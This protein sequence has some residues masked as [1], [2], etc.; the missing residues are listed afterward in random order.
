M[1]SHSGLGILPGRV[2]RFPT[3][4]KNGEGRPLK[5][6]HMG[7]N[8]IIH[9]GRHPLLASVPSGAYGYFVHSYYC[10]PATEDFILARTDYGDWFTSIVGKD[11]VYGIQFHPEKS[12]TVGLQILHNYVKMDGR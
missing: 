6:P 4:W 3:D 1:G 11:R 12:Q 8:R 10:E 7:W 2:V 9:D 5:I